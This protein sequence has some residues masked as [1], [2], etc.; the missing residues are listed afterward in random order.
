MP[1]ILR[2]CTR[3]CPRPKAAVKCCNRGQIQRADSQNSRYCCIY[4]VVPT[5]KLVNTL[6]FSLLSGF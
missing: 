4:H 3:I 6:K 2:I 1:G 5:S